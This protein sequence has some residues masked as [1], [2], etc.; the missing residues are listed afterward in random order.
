MDWRFFLIK[1]KIDALGSDR[2][3]NVTSM[4]TDARAPMLVHFMA[5]GIRRPVYVAEKSS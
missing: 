3:V 1:K 4:G 2:P 5:L